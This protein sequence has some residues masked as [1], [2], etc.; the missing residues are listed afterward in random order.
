[1]SDE[2]IHPED[3]KD[4]EKIFA[5]VLR[6]EYEGYGIEIYMS[7]AQARDMLAVWFEAMMGVPESVSACFMHFAQLMTS[8]MQ[9][10]QDD[11]RE[12]DDLN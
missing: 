10:V 8:L 6:D 4:L 9:A 12:N 7:R 2:D 5:R 3:R 11:D 1:V